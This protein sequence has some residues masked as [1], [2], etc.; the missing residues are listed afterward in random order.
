MK[1]ALIAPSPV[2]F[3]IGGAEK[4]WWGMLEHINQHTG[5]EAELIK[6]PSPERNFGELIRSYE[7]FS[8]M[9]LSHF[10]R[11]ISTK[12]PAWMVDH[13]EHYCYLQHKL[14]GLYDTYHF[15][16]QPEK[17]KPKKYPAAYQPLIRLL[18]QPPQRQQLPELFAQLK[19][20]EQHAN[21]D[22][23][24]AFP[25]PLTRAVVH[26][27]DAI[28]Q[29]PG[30][31]RHYGAISYNVANRRDYFP[32]GTEVQVVHHPSDLKDIHGG[33]YTHIFTVSRLD[34]PKR[35]DLLIQAFRQLPD[36]IELRI[37]G[38]GPEEKK[39]KALAEGDPR[40]R[41]LGRITDREIIDQYAD[42][43]FVPF[44]PYDEDFGLITIEA[45]SAGKAVLT[46]T[47]AGGVNEFVENGV[48]GFS[49]APDVESLKAAM[50]KLLADPAATKQ[51][52]E[53]ARDKVA[54]ISW[55]ATLAPLLAPEPETP[56]SVVTPE[57]KGRKKVVVTST[58]PAWP[59]QGGGQS[60]LYNMYAQLSQTMDVAL[61]CTGTEQRHM[62][63]L[64]DLTEHV[65]PESFT[66][67]VH[68]KKLQ[69]GRK[70]PLGD[71][72]AIDGIFK[73][74]AYMTVLEDQVRDADL[75]IASHPY[76]YQAIRAVWK[77]PIAYDAHNVEADMKAAVL[78]GQ[79]NPEPLL[80]K[81]RDTEAACIHESEWLVACSQDDLN[82]FAALYGNIQC[83]TAVAGNGV[84]LSLTRYYR[85]D[86]RRINR[87]RLGLHPD[88]EALLFMGSWHGPNLD[89][90][91]LILH[92]AQ[93]RPQHQFWLLGSLCGHP[94]FQKLPNN[95]IPLGMLPEAEKQIVMAAASAAL[96]PMMSGSGTNLK[97]L[98][99]AAWGLDIISTPFGNRGIGFT[100]ESEVSLADTARFAHTLDA[101]FALTDDQRDQRTQ[102]ARHKVEC[103]FDWQACAEPMVNL[104]SD[105]LA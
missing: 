75:V 4:L 60:R 101:L 62:R 9:D 15:C 64:P 96:N 2:P 21:H 48:S 70:V 8:Q 18:L 94:D 33:K 67:K 83:P 81:V 37:A 44:M 53:Q 87:T 26:H 92:L 25:G 74:S 30:A 100:N 7:A 98:D 99:Y 6:I 69:H 63:L 20:L 58:F 24:C 76:L 5:H 39:L 66:Q 34:G 77:G 61:V 46:T 32:D 12:Y 17:L 38:S 36:D 59:P 1:I 90:A 51:M 65:I 56:P 22:R 72:A 89:A 16:G 35:L 28:A 55:E 68:A 49:V 13:P 91:K 23:F 103:S 3:T 104:A 102:A 41:F 80:Q 73:N 10:D 97:M 29:R 27:L 50:A 57:K 11:V 105:T 85:V 84:D 47:D 88:Q 52:G 93:E 54:H 45:M 95:V 14:R 42:A 78:D 43:L 79:K 86:E 19:V 40:I 71:I 31:I 82:R